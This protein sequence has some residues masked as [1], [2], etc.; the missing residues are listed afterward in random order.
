MNKFTGYLAYVY[1][2]K[3][4]LTYESRGKPDDPDAKYEYKA[5]VIFTDEDEADKVQDFI[6]EKGLKSTLKVV[7][8][9]NFEKEFRFP[10]P[11]EAGKKVWSITVRQKEKML[12]DGVEV[13]RPDDMKPKV[14]MNKDGKR[15]NIVHDTQPGNGSEGSVSFTTY[16]GAKG[17]AIYFQDIF[18]TKLV[19]YVTQS[20]PFAEIIT[21]TKVLDPVYAEVKEDK[22]KSEKPPKK[23]AKVQDD[24]D[25]DVPF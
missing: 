14:L 3:P 24:D 12:Q 11:E 18:V 1:A 10:L 20:D 4:T 22:P 2:A 19:P 23:A 7:K 9:E 5:T 25:S 8:A 17:F 13:D 21:E 15:V 16:K 6:D